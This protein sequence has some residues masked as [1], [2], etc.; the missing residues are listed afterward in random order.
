M[1][2]ECEESLSLYKKTNAKLEEKQ[3]ALKEEIQKVEEI[4]L[5]LIIAGKQDNSTSSKSA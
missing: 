2:A 1:Q 4:G 3:N 5:L